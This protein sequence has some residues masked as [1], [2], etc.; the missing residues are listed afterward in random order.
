MTYFETNPTPLFAADFD[1]FRIPHPRWPLM[2]TR[3]KQMGLEA[4]FITVP[5][6]FHEIEQGVIDLNGTSDARRDLL[7]LLQACETLDLR[8]LLHLG[9]YNDSGLLGEGLPMWLLQ[10]D[11]SGE[12]LTEATKNW[13][14]AISKP[15][16]KQQW[17]DG[18]I[19]AVQLNSKTD[20]GR[21]RR[22]SQQL[23]EVKWPIWL[24][25]RYHG[26][27]ALNEAYGTAYRTVSNVPFPEETWAEES[28]PLEK[29]AKAFLEEA[30]EATQS[31]YLEE[32]VEA[33]WHVPI[34]P[35]ATEPPT[36]QPSLHRQSL[37]EQATVEPP[38]ADSPA[39]VHLQQPIQVDPDSPALST[40][41]VWAETA[42]IRADGSLRR[43]F[44]VVRQSL[45]AH[46]L[47][48]SRLEEGQLIVPVEN[49][50][51]VTCP[52]D[53]PLKIDTTV[54]SKTPVYRLRFNGDLIADENLKVSRK[55]LSGL[56]QAE[57]E[58]SQTDWVWVIPDEA[59]LEGLPLTYLRTLLAGQML[60][61][62]QAATLAE[63]L[64]QTLS[65]DGHKPQPQL[66][67]QPSPGTSYMLNEARRGLREADA[68]LRKAL[69]SI[70][71]LEGGFATMLGQKGS[72]ESR[73]ASEPVAIDPQAFEGKARDLLLEIGEGCHKVGR[74]LSATAK[75]LQQMID[76]ELTIEQYRHLCAEMATPLQSTHT[77][78]LKHIALLRLELASEELPLV[79]WR[80]HDQVQAIAES[81]RWGVV[82][83]GG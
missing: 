69:A 45:W 51:F 80:V 65:V 20:D 47:P 13:Y 79:L 22:L 37:V 30:N 67:S 48:D 41:L 2:L 68:A 82:R 61:L 33:G 15:L 50:L 40:G 56:Y 75:H 16:I 62:K 1:Y 59:A 64:G 27:D 81:L 66:A 83:H 5:W 19:V 60:S 76:G 35:S 36:N 25:K 12:A 54:E 11:H 32:L 44:W 73:P 42:P 6:G 78:L 17:S 10:T 9:P 3:L 52:G 55:K 8:C 46:R 14:R 58:V 28:T 57:D 23:T 77:L 31:G 34:Y 53:T 29:D 63:A 49:G 43:K 71:E 39:I 74:V 4:L 24:R 21:P 72:P 7:G 26:I 18:P 38:A 70:G